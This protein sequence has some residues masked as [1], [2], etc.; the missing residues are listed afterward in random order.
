MS[1]G[2]VAD[3]VRMFLTEALPLAEKAHTTLLIETVGIFADTAALRALFESFISDNLAALWDLHSPFRMNGE[4]PE[5]TIR[6]LGAYVRH[7]HMKDSESA[8]KPTLVG[9][10]S[11]PIKSIMNALKSVNYDGFISIEWDPAWDEVS[12]IDIIFPHF[13]SYM[14]CYE[15]ARALRCTTIM[16]VQANMCGKRNP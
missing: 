1:E 8:D 13:I 11:L 15:L 9:E 6:N 3:K 5:D 16:P 14:S 2:D 10:G 4:A 12:D 7:V